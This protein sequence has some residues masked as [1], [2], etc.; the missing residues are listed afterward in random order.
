MR[1]F[2]Y[3]MSESTKYQFQLGD[4][5]HV[6]GWLGLNFIGKVVKN[7]NQESEERVTVANIADYNI[8]NV[9]ISFLKWV[10]PATLGLERLVDIH[11]K[12]K[13]GGVSPYPLISKEAS[14]LPRLNLTSGTIMLGENIR[15]DVWL[16]RQNDVAKCHRLINT[17]IEAFRAEEKRQGDKPRTVMEDM[18]SLPWFNPLAWP[19][20]RHAAILAVAFARSLK[21]DMGDDAFLQ[22][23][24]MNRRKPDSA[25]CHSHTFCDSDMIMLNAFRATFDRSAKIME[26][27]PDVALINEAW[28]IARKNNFYI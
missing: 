5:V 3:T 10:D 4:T 6:I 13:A 22:M 17:I 12:A 9:P 1:L 19:V 2:R 7:N 15:I 20:E 14:H 26:S 16:H 28:A 23:V 18:A 8:E 27:G 11:A 24:R 21:Q 25:C